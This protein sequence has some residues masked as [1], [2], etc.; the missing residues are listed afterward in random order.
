MADLEIDFCGVRSPNPFW[1]ASAPPTN[2]GDQVMRAFDAGW[3]GA[4]WK[5]LGNPIVN[6]TSRFG[7]IDYGSTRLMGLN[8]IELITDRPLE[9]NLR[10]MRE[11]KRR[12]PKHTLIA[13]LM[14]ETK[15]EWK[16]I[17]RKAED[18][19]ADLLE[20]NFGC[21][22]GMCERGMGSAVGQEPKVLEEIARWA[23]EYAQVPVIVKL[24]PNVGDILEPGEA[25]VRAGVPALSLINTVKSLMG[26]DL[27]R[28]VPLPRVGN[29]STNGGYC[30]PAV[31]PIA[32]HL[33]S[34][35]S[36]HPQC[37]KL[38]ISGIG[39]ISNWKDAAEFIALG[40]TSVQVCTAV[41][42]Y[43]Y[44]IV[45]DMIEGLSNFLDEK[46]MKSVMELRGRAV[47]AYQDWG[48]LDLSYKLVAKIN[49]DKCIGCQLCYVA[50]MDGSHQC[51]HV[52]GR[53]EEE[54]RK[55]GH[56]HIPK[57]I[58]NR[59]V[60][61]KAGTPGARVPFVDNDECVGCNLCQLVCPVPDCITM[62]ELPTGKPMETWNDRVAKGTDFVPGGL[63]A[64]QAARR[65]S[66]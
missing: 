21:P 61:A 32:L 10:E 65:K 62:E 44:R 57:D 53:T 7:G 48:E 31:K 39:G 22:H 4:V 26:V 23:M 28:M 38:A 5:T 3:G 8:N 60:T 63:E 54:S 45:E 46:G 14:V 56:T 13:S 25:A 2:T 30:G 66:G 15:E 6:V 9:V 55:A 35:L 12:Y 42:H 34:Q 47:P 17:I 50:C 52:P 19:G 36:R 49:E 40:A 27:D 11:V 37:G 59:V 20:L 16:E 64:T 58:P 33:M 51:I 1:L 24:T 41:M 18:T 29:A 43:G